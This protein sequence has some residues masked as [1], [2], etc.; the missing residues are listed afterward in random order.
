RDLDEQIP[1]T[2]ESVLTEQLDL[3]TLFDRILGRFGRH[4]PR[5]VHAA[6]DARDLA[7]G[8]CE[9]VVPDERH[10]FLE[11]CRRMHHPEEPALARV[12]DVAAR[13]EWTGRGDVDVAG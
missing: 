2:A 1:E 13:S 3:S 12:T 7:H 6:V 4:Q 8:R 10:L 5:R 9:V 11:R